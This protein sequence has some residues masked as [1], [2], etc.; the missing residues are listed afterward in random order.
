M[1]KEDKK[2]ITYRPEPGK[3]E[4]LEEAN[5]SAAEK[6]AVVSNITME[7]YCEDDDSIKTAE[8]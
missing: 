8:D 4:A 5:K 2:A 1:M 3:D 7:L 6:V